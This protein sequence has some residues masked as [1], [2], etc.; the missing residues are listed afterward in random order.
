MA[1]QFLGLSLFI[2]LLSFFI[3][4]NAIS[5]FEV[6]KTRPV[7]NSLT[8]AFSSQE[9]KDI[10]PPGK[11]LEA[12]PAS[13]LGSNLDRIQAL[14][15]SQI[16]AVQA[17]KNRL[18]NMMF[19]RMPFEEFQNAVISSLTIPVDDAQAIGGDSYVNMLPLLVSLLQT[20]SDV[21]YKMDMVLNLEQDP[22]DMVL[23][24][25][26]QFRAA[27]VSVADIAE[28]LEN[29]GLPKYQ[30]T[31]GLKQGEAGVVELMFRRY[32]PFNPIQDQV[33]TGQPPPETES[34]A[35]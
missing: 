12:S 3:I 14:F 30:V 32:E 6:T 5:T 15:E 25:P 28:R 16:T 35:P 20:N 26:D 10:R 27:N 8:M 24:A 31:T 23:D 2:M 29:A 33:T 9:T 19:I 7:L 34:E 21:S 17:S 4:L 1:N 11:A 18:G 22:S 13:Q